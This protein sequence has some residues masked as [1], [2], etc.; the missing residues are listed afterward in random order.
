MKR[1]MREREAAKEP[2]ET[3]CCSFFFLGLFVERE[4]LEGGGLGGM[5][6]E[7]GADFL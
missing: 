5:R 1:L 3:F 7:S 2:Q 6:E 4:E